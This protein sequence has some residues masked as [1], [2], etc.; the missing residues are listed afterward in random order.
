M[1]ESAATR[2]RR[3]RRRISLA[4]LDPSDARGHGARRLYR[5]RRARTDRGGV[6]ESIASIIQVQWN[7]PRHRSLT[8]IPATWRGV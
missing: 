5:A 6:K 8:T 4:P 2:C 1:I 7:Q 3:H